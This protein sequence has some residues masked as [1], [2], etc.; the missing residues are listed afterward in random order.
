MFR[1]KQQNLESSI[2]YSQNEPCLLTSVQGEQKAAIIISLLE[3]YGIP[4][5]KGYTGSD[6]YLHIAWGSAMFTV[7]IYV[8]GSALDAAHDI[9]RNEQ[10]EE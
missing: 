6:Q 2:D 10:I 4:A 8:P 1:K 7:H 3:S 5:M 9:L